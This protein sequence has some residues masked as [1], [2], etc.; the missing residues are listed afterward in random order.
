VK[1]PVMTVNDEDQHQQAGQDRSPSCWWASKTADT[2]LRLVGASSWRRSRVSSGVKAHRLAASRDDF[3]EAG[4]QG[5][6]GQQP[7]GAP[8][9]T[10]VSTPACSSRIAAVCRSTC[11]ETFLVASDGHAGPPSGRVLRPAGSRRSG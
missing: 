3:L 9:I 7:A 8:T 1:L 6:K 4:K 10:E 5:L 2:V 11:G